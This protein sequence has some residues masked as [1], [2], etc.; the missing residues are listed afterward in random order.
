MRK[1][2][3]GWGRWK[4]ALTPAS[5]ARAR[6]RRAHD[7]ARRRRRLFAHTTLCLLEIECWALDQTRSLGDLGQHTSEHILVR[8]FAEHGLR[9]TD[10]YALG[11]S[12][13]SHRLQLSHEVEVLR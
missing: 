6:D 12:G 8:R 5:L 13:V 4:W 11:T 10:A 9:V 1:G 3:C 2:G 7:A